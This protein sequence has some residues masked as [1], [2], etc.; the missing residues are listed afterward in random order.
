[1]VTTRR[2][3]NAGTRAPA[4]VGNRDVPNG[5]HPEGTPP[6]QTTEYAARYSDARRVAA[7]STDSADPTPVLVPEPRRRQALVLVASDA[8]D[9]VWLGFEQDDGDNYF[10]LA[11]GQAYTH[12][13]ASPVYVW[14]DTSTTIYSIDEVN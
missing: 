4:Q 11:A 14:S 5:P 2:I 7:I 1:M 10:P 12:N 3:V 13:S 6:L 9:T 8:A